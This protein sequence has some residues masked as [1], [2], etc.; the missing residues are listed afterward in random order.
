MYMLIPIVLFFLNWLK[1]V[2]GIGCSVFLLAGFCVL[3][4]QDYQ[5]E[6][7][8]YLLSLR[9]TVTILIGIFFFVW[10][11]GAGGFFVQTG[12]N[13]GRNAIFRDLIHYS[14]PVR[15]TDGNDASL[16]YYFTHWLV[17]ALGAKC[18]GLET[19]WLTGN[20]LLFLWDFLGILLSALMILHLTKAYKSAS[21][22][23]VV[24]LFIAMWSGLNLVGNALSTSLGF[25]SGQFGL[26]SNE[27]WL[28]YWRNGFDCSYLYRS[29]M[30]ALSQVFNQTVV[31]WVAVPL[32][33]E[34]KKIKNMAFTGLCVL[35]FAP[36]P[37]VGMFMLMAGYALCTGWDEWK[38]KKFREIKLKNIFSIQNIFACIAILPVFG[39][40]FMMNTAVNKNSSSILFVPLEAFDS[41]RILTLLLFYLLE[42]GIYCFLIF[43]R[44]KKDP[45]YWILIISLVI[46]PVFQVGG[47]RDFCMNASLPALYTLMIFMIRYLLELEFHEK[48]RKVFIAG[49]CVL[50]IA[51]ASPAADVMGDIMMIHNTNQFPITVDDQKTLSDKKPEDNINFLVEHQEKHFFYKYLGRN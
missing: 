34:N 21:G 5:S 8:S 44:Y 43:Q 20:V 12:D 41:R 27:G 29:N 49:C 47:G 22:T 32:F 4:R 48:N 28:D 42:F 14:W 25:S 35:P 45:I 11:S 3:Y 10:L 6:T 31:P 18:F 26:S 9:Q 46:I 30:D 38:R 23:V 17:P 13:Q 15:Y 16:V 51:F 24:I 19:G 39:T 1:P 33:L 37:F 50:T 40:F 7:E 2:I 36:I